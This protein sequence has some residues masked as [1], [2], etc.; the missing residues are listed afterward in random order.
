ML[1]L[2]WRCKNVS[3]IPIGRLLRIWACSSLRGR[4][5]RFPGAVAA[6]LLCGQCWT[7][8]EAKSAVLFLIPAI[9]N[10]G[11][12]VTFHSDFFL[13]PRGELSEKAG[14]FSQ[15]LEIKNCVKSM[16]VKKA[17]HKN[18]ISIFFTVMSYLH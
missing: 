15:P 18:K 11:A 17:Y 9:S 6:C 2:E 8:P 1:T 4:V 12:H 5:T 13:Q 7:S 14:E 10:T 16:F 3:S